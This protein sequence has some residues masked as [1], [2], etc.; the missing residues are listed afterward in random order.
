MERRSRARSI[1]KEHGNYK[2]LT[3]AGGITILKNGI[4]WAATYFLMLLMLFFYGGGRLSVSLRTRDARACLQFQ[5]SGPGIPAGSRE[6]IFEPFFT[7]KEKGSGL[8]LTVVRRIAEQHQG[9]VQVGDSTFDG[10][11]IEVCLPQLTGDDVTSHAS[12][13]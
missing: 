10:A 7:T 5:D 13:T 8:G 3:E 11:S 6:R 2:W 9:D 4:E 12:M 1:L